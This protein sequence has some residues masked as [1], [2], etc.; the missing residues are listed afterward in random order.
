MKTTEMSDQAMDALLRL[1][2]EVE[3]GEFSVS[4]LRQI[5]AQSRARPSVAADALWPACLIALAG[6]GTLLPREA[7]AAWLAT[8]AEQWQAVFA[9]APSLHLPSWSAPHLWPVEPGLW[10]PLALAAGLLVTLMPLL[11][12]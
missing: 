11:Q 7:P 6:A 5:A 3:D 12:D 10:L 2:L 4:V 1:P 9:A 8:M